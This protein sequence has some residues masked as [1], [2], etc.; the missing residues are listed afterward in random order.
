[1]KKAPAQPLNGLIDGLEVLNALI[2]RNDEVS[3][4]EL[5]DELGME[6]TRMNRILKTLDY[7]GLASRTKNRKYQAGPGIY[8]LAAMNMANSRLLKTA[9]REMEDLANG[10]YITAL[11]TL[12]RDKVA[13]LIHKSP[14]GNLIDSIG[15]HSLYPVSMSSIGMFLSSQLE[16]EEL[17]SI[18]KKKLP[19]GFRDIEDFIQKMDETRIRGY[20]RII[21]PNNSVSISVGIGEAPSPAAIAV[22][23]IMPDKEEDFV[24]TMKK[25][26]KRISD[27][28]TTG[29][30]I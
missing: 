18:H 6:L 15:S 27:K 16:N 23:G 24:A 28:I 25:V 5:A 3:C 30:S 14:D 7:I 13:Y 2:S 12:W 9:I 20:G 19:P 1:M 21:N 22:S 10:P 11:G 4:T 26:A 17:L 29:K 8:S